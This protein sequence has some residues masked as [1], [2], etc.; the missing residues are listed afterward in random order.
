MKGEFIKFGLRAENDMPGV[1]SPMVSCP[2]MKIQGLHVTLA[3]LG[4]YKVLANIPVRLLQHESQ[5]LDV[6]CG[7]RCDP[8][9]ND[10]LQMTAQQMFAYYWRLGLPRLQKWPDVKLDVTYPSEMP[11]AP[12]QGYK[13][14]FARIDTPGCRDSYLIL[15]SQNAVLYERGTRP[16]IG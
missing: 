1:G 8:K 13:S 3:R 16:Y 14:A 15:S 7:V 5:L 4:Y 11:A 6:I 12:R 9:P 10:R 2:I